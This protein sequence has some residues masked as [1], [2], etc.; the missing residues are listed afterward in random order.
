MTQVVDQPRTGIQRLQTRHKRILDMHLAGARR[1]DIATALNMTP[2][3]VGLIIKSPLF[4]DELARRTKALETNASEAHRESLSA[5]AAAKS[6]AEE[7]LVE[8]MRNQENEP[9][10]RFDAIRDILDRNGVGRG[11]QVAPVTHITVERMEVLV[12]AMK[13]AK[14][15]AQLPDP[16]PLTGD[17]DP[18]DPPTED[19]H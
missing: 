11:Q 4:Q 9:R 15:V 2:E 12:A 19:L 7:E 16:D 13:A 5:I 17:P 8:M 6:E 10:L 14:E 3:G 18:I 1:K